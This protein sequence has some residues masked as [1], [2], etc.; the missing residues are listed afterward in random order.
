M[1]LSKEGEEGFGEN[2]FIDDEILKYVRHKV[3]N[4]IYFI[5]NYWRHFQERMQ[6]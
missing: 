2:N 1:L 6:R 5:I 4:S 3:N